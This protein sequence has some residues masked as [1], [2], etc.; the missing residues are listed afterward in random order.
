MAIEMDV[1]LR[2]TIIFEPR[3]KPGRTAGT[4][5]S[6]HKQPQLKVTVSSK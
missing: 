3:K 2:V 4:P 5:N 1:T 6:Q